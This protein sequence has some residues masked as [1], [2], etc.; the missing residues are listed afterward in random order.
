MLVKRGFTQLQARKLA[1]ELNK[2]DAKLR[3]AL[4]K[5]LNDGFET[6]YTVQ[7]FSISG[8]MKQYDLTYPAAILSLDW[9]LKD[10]DNAIKC[11]KKGLR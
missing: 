11:I 3:P 1:E 7:G 10:P 9:I 6:D 5:W 4:E 2:V 8:L